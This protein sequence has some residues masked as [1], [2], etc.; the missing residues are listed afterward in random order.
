MENEVKQMSMFPRKKKK[1][2]Y[3]NHKHKYCKSTVVVSLEE[4]ELAECSNL[5]NSVA[6]CPGESHGDL[7]LS[8]ATK[9]DERS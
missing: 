9:K 7:P 3:I 2:M 1:L 5:V 8:R 4:D 6:L